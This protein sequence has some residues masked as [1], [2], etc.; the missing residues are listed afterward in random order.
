MDNME[1]KQLDCL[2]E[3]FKKEKLYHFTKISTA[4]KILKTNKLKFGVLKTMNDV[5]EA[6]KE[7]D[8]PPGTFMDVF[9]GF[10]KLV[11]R[12]KLESD[13]KGKVKDNVD[14]LQQLSLSYDEE[15]PMYDNFPMWG[16][17]ADKATGACLVFDYDSILAKINE[18]YKKGQR[19]IL[20]DKVDY[21]LSGVIPIP[22]KFNSADKEEIK[23]L[24]FKKTNDWKFEHEFRV[25]AE[26]DINEPVF[27]DIKDCICAIIIYNHYKFNNICKGYA[28]RRLKNL[29]SVPILE[30]RLAREK[31]DKS[32]IKSRLFTI[33][34]NGM[35]VD[36]LSLIE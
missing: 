6:Y 19:I 21:D 33:R 10:E 15:L 26:S 7:A 1:Q 20:S 22:D 12:L 34:P 30:Y 5:S 25:L 27:L 23:R 28:Y 13:I 9:G 35:G 3:N 4:F 29:T 11:K 16:L 17:Y 36:I 18:F 8:L 32:L 2:I 14:K 31:R 24:F